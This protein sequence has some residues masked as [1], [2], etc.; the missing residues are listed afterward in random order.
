MA[1]GA[2]AADAGALVSGALAA[3]GGL[4]AGAGAASSARAM[5]RKAGDARPQAK[6][7]QKAI[8]DNRIMV[9]ASE[10]IECKDSK[11]L[12]TK[13]QSH[14]DEGAILGCA[15]RSVKKK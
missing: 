9:L 13:G 14:I 5:V 12:E 8:R 15:G 11:W 10:N 7:R 4:S 3:A 6:V 2:G 1:V